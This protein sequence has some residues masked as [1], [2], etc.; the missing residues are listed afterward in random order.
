MAHFLDGTSEDRPGLA[1]AMMLTALAMLAVQD[2]LA[3][4]KGKALVRI[5]Q[6]EGSLIQGELVWADATFLKIRA[7]D[8]SS[9]L[10]AK[11]L[12]K[13]LEVL[14]GTDLS[15]DGDVVPDRLIGVMNDLA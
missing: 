8:G 5:T 9:V 13:S 1:A 14:D 2:A 4:A 15:A 3:R 12:V 11:S 7:E 6:A 10:V